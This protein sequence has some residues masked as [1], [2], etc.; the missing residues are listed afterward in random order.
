MAVPFD[1]SLDETAELCERPGVE[2]LE[3]FGSATAEEFGETSDVDFI[4]S[5]ADRSSGYADRYLDFAEALEEVLGREVGLVA[6]R[7]IRNPFVALQPRLA[8]GSV[9]DKGKKRLLDA[10]RA[11]DAIQEFV[12]GE[13]F[14][15]YRSDL[16]L[17]SAVERQLEIIGEALSQAA[18]ENKELEEQI[19]AIPHNV[20]L[21]NRVI[22]GHDRVDDEIVWDVV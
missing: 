11:C 10:Y 1:Q 19:P 22:Q 20:A 16:L 2:R 5:F 7:W 18:S 15:T 12:S 6:E 17:R 21:R 9:T 4:V 13:A 3:L 14:G 8:R